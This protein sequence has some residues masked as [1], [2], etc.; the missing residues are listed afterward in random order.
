MLSKLGIAT[1]VAV[2]ATLGVAPATFAANTPAPPVNTIAQNAYPLTAT[3]QS[4]VKGG[5]NTIP[6]IVTVTNHSK[7]LRFGPL[8]YLD[9]WAT[10]A[11]SS[12]PTHVIDAYA[13]WLG[14][15]IQAWYAGVLQPGQTKTFVVWFNPTVSFPSYNDPMTG[16]VYTSPTMEVGVDY[17]PWL[18]LHE[19]FFHLNTGFGPAS[20]PS[21]PGGGK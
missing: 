18:T 10:V 14:K 2:L 13:P 6:Y 4:P 1:I 3:A 21:Y 17:Q 11:S 8:V 9:A 19:N 16:A 12:D 20:Q 5:G 15:T 7:T